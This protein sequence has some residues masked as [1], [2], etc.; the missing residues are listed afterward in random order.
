MHD[1]THVYPEGT[2]IRATVGLLLLLLTVLPPPEGEAGAM[3]HT[4]QMRRCTKPG[5][6]Y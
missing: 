3:P 2:L 5:P 1:P 6:D 4:G